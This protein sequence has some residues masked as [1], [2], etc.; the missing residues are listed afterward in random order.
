MKLQEGSYNVAPS[1][2]KPVTAGADM[3]SED[4]H[5]ATEKVLVSNQP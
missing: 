1:L 4:D 2:H 5:D 3:Q